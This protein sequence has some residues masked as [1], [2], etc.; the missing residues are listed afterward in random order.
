MK[1]VIT[2]ILVLVLA[3]MANG[4]Q[5]LTVNGEDVDSITI[6][7]GQSCTVEVDSN[8][9]NGYLDNIGFDDCNGLGD[10]YH[11]ETTPE[12]GSSAEVNPIDQPD[13]CGYEIITYYPWTGVHF[14][15]QYD[16]L[17]I[18]ETILKLYGHPLQSKI[19]KD[20]LRIKV[21]PPDIG[22]AFTYQGWLRDSSVPS[23]GYYSTVRM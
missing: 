5:K 13:F 20:S 6:K 15:F 18:G 2:L 7:L 9:H 1:R 17:Q 23:C 10:F 12:A 21:I 3:S 8:D 19:E 4:D 22:T 16:A 14:I 11:L